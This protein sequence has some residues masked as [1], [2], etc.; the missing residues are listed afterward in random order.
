MKIIEK[1]FTI[2][3]LGENNV[4]KTSLTKS[5]SNNNLI[6]S[7]HMDHHEYQIRKKFV[8][9]F[10][11]INI[12]DQDSSGLYQHNDFMRAADA[13]II[14]CDVTD[15]TTFISQLYKVVQRYDDDPICLFVANK[16]DIEVTK[17]G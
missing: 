14:V 10:I 7:V 1:E 8:N 16:C 11:T 6:N 9:E 2:T 15:K 17:R 12:L 3:I 13:Y 5:L 4:G